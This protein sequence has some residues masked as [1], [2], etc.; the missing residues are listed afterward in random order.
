MSYQERVWFSSKLE[1][2]IAYQER[3]LI[4]SELEP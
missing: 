2:W 3:V 1:A 4:S